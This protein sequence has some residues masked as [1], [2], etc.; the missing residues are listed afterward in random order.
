MGKLNWSCTFC[1]MSSS[2]RSSVQRHIDNRNIH[3]GLAEVVPYVQYSIGIKEGNY[4]PQN[5]RQ[6]TQSRAPY[7]N[8]IEAEV[9][10]LVI[11][12]IA[13]RIYN[14]LVKNEAVLDNLQAVATANIVSKNLKD[15]LK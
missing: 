2:R 14:N 8:K 11:R 13:K 6:F 10:N 12:E 7:L 1:G 5:A 4:I 3:N 9:E 15:I